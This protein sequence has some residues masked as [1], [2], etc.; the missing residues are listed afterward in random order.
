VRL[1][2]DT[3][4]LVSALLSPRGAPARVLD[5][6]FM[7]DHVLL[8]DDRILAEYAEVLARPRFGFAPR[9][10]AALLAWIEAWGEP[11]AAEPLRIRLAD[12]DDLPF[13]EVAVTG[14]ADA[15]VTGNP[16]HFDV[17][18]LAGTLRVVVPADLRP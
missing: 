3:N 16:R 8:L 2:L 15:L 13:V 5:R 10:V 6:I 11:V 9:D 18:D 14:R 1:V 7:G 12:P 17:R 4:V